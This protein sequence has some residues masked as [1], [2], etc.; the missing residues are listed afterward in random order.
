VDYYSGGYVHVHVEDGNDYVLVPAGKPDTHL[1]M[2][3]AAIIHLPCK[4]IYLAASSA[5]DF[6]QC[7]DCL[8]IIVACSTKAQDYASQQIQNRINAG[9]ISYVGKYSA[10]D[11]ETLLGMGCGLAIEST[12]IY[13]SPKI[14]EQLE[15]LQIPVLVERSSYEENPLG[16][17]EWIKLYGVL[18]QKEEEAEGFF[19]EQCK[20]VEALRQELSDRQE[21]IKPKTVAFFYLASNGYVNI[22]KSGD[23]LC[24]MIEI[25]GGNYAFSDLYLEEEN[26]LSTVNI[27]WEDF[28]KKA[29]D[30]DIL[31]YNGTIDGSVTS[32]EDLLGKNALFENCR[33]VQNHDVWYTDANLYQE[34]S[35]V[36]DIIE[37]LYYVIGENGEGNTEFLHHLD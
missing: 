4:Q 5:M 19:E 23:Y 1:G 24:K 14:K 17:M 27:N 35:K 29:V 33:A 32:M 8:D 12:M 18:L 2:E 16:R 3:S 31:I 26:A 34:C 15:S 22:R 13:H 6:F 20:K 9:E 28:Y 21:G 30:A 37:D 10:P 25:A 11:Y 36:A 7:L